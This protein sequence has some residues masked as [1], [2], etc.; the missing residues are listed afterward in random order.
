VPSR[1]G[2]GKVLSG[3]DGVARARYGFDDETEQRISD[4]QC[5][6]NG[7]VADGVAWRGDFDEPPYSAAGWPGCW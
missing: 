5:A 4:R 2:G 3:A 7:V 6:L 1:P